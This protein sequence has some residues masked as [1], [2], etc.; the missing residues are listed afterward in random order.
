MKRKVTYDRN[1]VG[2]RLLERRKQKGWSR[3]YVAEK[4]GLVEKYYADIERGTCGMSIETLIAL[5]ELYGFTLDALIYG[6]KGD[7]GI[8]GQD[9]NLLKQLE[10]MSPQLQDTCRQL[11]MVF[12]N[13]MHGGDKENKTVL[14]ADVAEGI[15]G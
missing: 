3:K 2:K 7:L 8:L 14:S 11:L 6:E 5:K 10:T 13:G 9:K 4:I 1:A 15:S 12:V